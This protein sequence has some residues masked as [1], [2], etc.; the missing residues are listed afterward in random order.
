MTRGLREKIVEQILCLFGDELPF[1]KTIKGFVQRAATMPR[2]I[3]H[4]LKESQD[5]KMPAIMGGQNRCARSVA[6]GNRR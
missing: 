4:R 5:K 6:G 3:Q 2:R 1:T